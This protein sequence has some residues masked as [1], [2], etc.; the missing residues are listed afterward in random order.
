MLY[1][2]I[3]FHAGGGGILRCSRDDDYTVYVVAVN[4]KIMII[5]THLHNLNGIFAR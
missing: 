4:I 3:N 2:R 1:T 5:T